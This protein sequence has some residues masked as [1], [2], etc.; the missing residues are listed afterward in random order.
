MAKIYKEYMQ[1]PTAV[2]DITPSLSRQTI[3]VTEK[4]TANVAAVP[5]GMQGMPIATKGAVENHSISITPSAAVT[6][7][8]IIGQSLTGEPV[9]VNV[10]ELVSGTLEVIPTMLTQTLD[11][12]NYASTSVGPIYETVD[13]SSTMDANLVATNLGKMY[14]YEGTPTTSYKTNRYYIIVDWEAPTPV[15]EE[16]TT[17]ATSQVYNATQ[18]N[19][20]VEVQ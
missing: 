8:Y 6:T 12:T 16:P 15:P 11:V 2:I 4:A 5:T 3:D 13:S 7:G 1:T 17:L 9:T 14:K 20:T 18:V 19:D 10:S